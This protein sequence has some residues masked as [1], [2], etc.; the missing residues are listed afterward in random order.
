MTNMTGE[1]LSVN[2]LM[3]AMARADAAVEAAIHHFRAEPDYTESRYI[4]K[5]E[6]GQLPAENHG[7]LLRAIDQALGELNIEYQAKRS[8]GRLRAPILQVMRTGWY[9]RQKQQLVADGKRLFQAKTILLDAKLGYTPE[10]EE[11]EAEV[12]LN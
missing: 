7:D 6:A 1:K 11:L 9:Q 5:V 3:E 10:P 12:H 8:S 2:Q 4:F